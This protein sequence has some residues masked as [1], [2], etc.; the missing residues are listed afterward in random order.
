[1]NSNSQRI[2]YANAQENSASDTH[3]Y[4]GESPFSNTTKICRVVLKYAVIRS[5]SKYNNVSYTY[6]VNQSP[7]IPIRENH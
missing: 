2:L 1:M 5:S 4:K 3:K 7:E 6:I